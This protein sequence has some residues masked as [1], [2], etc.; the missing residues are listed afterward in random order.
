MNIECISN[1]RPPRA[2]IDATNVI[3][4]PET[5]VPASSTGSER[6]RRAS[7][8]QLEPWAGRLDEPRIAGQRARYR[9]IS[10]G[11]RRA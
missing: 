9:G 3:L 1:G 6:R 4:T 11:R 10:M 2:V 5:L 7:E 8:M